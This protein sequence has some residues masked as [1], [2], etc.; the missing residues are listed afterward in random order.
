MGEMTIRLD[1]ALAIDLTSRAGELGM[2]PDA[3]AARLLA[4]ALTR[5]PDR[6][7]AAARAIQAAQPHRS[8]Y[9]SVDLIRED[10]ERR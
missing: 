5:T 3:L 10:R 9:D 8:P 4:G 7:A 6:R 2:T 1:E